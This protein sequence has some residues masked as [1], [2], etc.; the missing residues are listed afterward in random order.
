MRLG[1]APSTIVM[2]NKIPWAQA[3]PTGGGRRQCL[4]R[5]E[6]QSASTLV[7][8]NSAPLSNCWLHNLRVVRPNQVP[9]RPIWFSCC[10]P[11]G[12]I[13]YMPKELLLSGRMTQ[14][15]DIYSFGLMS[16]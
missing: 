7:V 4:G 9:A 14:A 12:T 3:R 2:D 1:Y 8:F 10:H 5:V 15:T 16:E 11:P 6:C 13:V